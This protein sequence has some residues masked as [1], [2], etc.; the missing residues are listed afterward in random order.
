MI[1]IFKVDVNMTD[2]KQ[3]DFFTL[4][5]YRKM[6]KSKCSEILNNSR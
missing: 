6:S 2:N 3:N 4:V 5:I 1:L